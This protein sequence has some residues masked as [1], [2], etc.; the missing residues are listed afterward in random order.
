MDDVHA[1]VSA[2]TATSDLTDALGSVLLLTDASQGAVTGYSYGAYGAQGATGSSGVPALTSP[3]QYAGAEFNSAD[4]LLYLR[5][6]FYSPQLQR[7]I[8]EDPIGVAGGINTYAYVKG[9]PISNTDPLGLLCFNF[10]QFADFIR[11]NSF[12]SLIGTSAVTDANLALTAA[13]I[14]FIYP[15]AGLGTAAGSP[16]SLLSWLGLQTGGALNLPFQIPGLSTANP[17]RALGRLGVASTI[18]EGFY[19]LSIEAQA[20]IH[21]TSSSDCGCKGN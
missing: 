16:T 10:D 6:R 9:N 13:N 3:F 18:F 20:A 5:N 4:Q 8:S 19:D 17:L 21:A 14:P 7:F 12:D 2:G 1:Q 11:D 15:R